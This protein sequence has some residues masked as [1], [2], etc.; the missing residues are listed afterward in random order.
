MSIPG[1]DPASGTFMLPWWAVALGAAVVIV[2]V[3]DAVVRNS[4]LGFFAL[5]LRVAIVVVIAWAAWL[6]IDRMAERERLDE[7]LALQSRALSL[8]AQAVMPGSPLACLDA[9]AGESVET[10]CEKA[11]FAS[12]E[13]VATATSYTGARIALLADLIDYGAR[14]NADYEEIAPGLHAALASDRFG[15]VAQVLANRHSCTAESC[16]NLALFRDPGRIRA[17]FQERTFS[18]YVAR[19]SPTWNAQTTVPSSPVA[20]TP[21]MGV[22]AAAAPM[23]PP[24]TGGI[25]PVPPGFNLPSAASIPPVSI[26]TPEITGSPQ[27]GAV[28]PSPEPVV[29]PVTRRPAAKTKSRAGQATPAPAP[30][31]PVQITPPAASGSPRGQ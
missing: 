11:L 31:P 4:V 19:N 16:D 1:F 30:S 3:V 12:P 21:V 17:N 8:T 26:M 29:P 18:G 14:A 7:R 5:G 28:S 13:T 25:S 6:L 27:P 15:F 2:L 9:T 23:V 10:S 20:T 22:P 24:T